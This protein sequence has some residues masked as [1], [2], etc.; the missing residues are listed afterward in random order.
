MIIKTVLLVCFVA[1]SSFCFS[2]DVDSNNTY[3][4]D[5]VTTDVKEL[6]DSI[7]KKIEKKTQINLNYLNPQDY[8]LKDIRIVGGKNI[9]KETILLI[10][11][12]EIGGK[13]VL[14]GDRITRAIQKMWKQGLFEDIQFKIDEVSGNEVSLAIHVKERPRLS[15]FT[16]RGIRKNDVDDL[17]DQIGLMRGKVVT[18]NLKIRIN[19]IIKKHYITKGFLNTSVKIEEKED[20]SYQNGVILYIY[21]SKKEKVKINEIYITGNT[22]V[23]SAALKRKM[24][25][26]KE[27]KWYRLFKASKYTINDYTTDKKAIIDYYNNQGFRDVVIEKDTTYDFANGLINI[28]MKISEGNRYYFRKITFSGNTKYADSTLSQVLAI[29]EGTLYD[30][31]LLDQQ[32]FAS[33][34]GSDISSLYMDYGYLFFQVTPIEKLIENDSIDLEIRIYE[35][36]QA[37]INKVIIEGNV[38]TNDHVIRREIRTIPG[39]KFS[40]S[41]IIRT[42]RELANLGYFNPETMDVKPIPHPENGTV[43]II[44]KLEE[45]STDQ[46]E[47]SA[48]WGANR[49]V[50]TLGLGLNNFSARNMF[51]KGG[52]QPIPHGDGQKVSI[53]ASSTGPWFQSYN[54]TFTEPW[55][56]G[57]RPNSLSVAAF[58]TVQNWT[59]DIQKDAGERTRLGIAGGSINLG[60]RMQWPD[61]NFIL[62]SGT[63]Y[64]R[65]NANNWAQLNE[66]SDRVSHVITW[67]EVFS[68]NTIA[69]GTIYPREGSRFSLTAKTTPPFSLIK[70]NYTSEQWNEYNWK[71][72]YKIKFDAEVYT[73]IIDKIVV[74]TRASLGYMNVYSNRNTLTNVDRFIMPYDPMSSQQGYNSN[75]IIGVDPVALRGYGS[76]EFGAMRADGTRQKDE[77]GSKFQKFS[78][79]FRVPISLNPMSTIFLLAFVE[80][81]NIWDA[82]EVFNPFDNKR[83]AGLG[84]RVS[85]PMFGLIGVD[86]GYGFDK[87]P[88]IYDYSKSRFSNGFKMS[89][90]MGVQPY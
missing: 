52:W 1:I 55:L 26:T 16:F 87:D 38:K 30:Q 12:L 89:F 27:K 31:S 76:G 4:K 19:N 5:S 51:K 82:D 68:R 61:D 86:F 81:G 54:A 29:S 10:C 48:G 67:Q 47:M 59:S 62:I 35:G 46:I 66:L 75:F 44:Y 49:V 73:P 56:G 14:P 32:L 78:A 77:F 88:L 20:T 84:V 41:D 71:E 45:K 80:A 69:G 25:E 64:Q 22:E 37:T 39:Q 7:L 57:T 8:I 9:D 85:L 79:E 74:K 24:K 36:Q 33:P 40:R 34:S 3:L 2:Q 58:N 65:I 21:V 60:I 53:R 13:I 23:S 11:D 50:G 90:F 28:E 18:D 42:Q 83:A 15:K 63:E 72:Y 70:P 6:P 43:D 17:K